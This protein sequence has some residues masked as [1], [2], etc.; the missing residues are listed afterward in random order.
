MKE[1]PLITVIIPVYNAE[2][3]LEQCLDSVRNQTLT[4]LEIICVDDCSQDGSPAILERYQACDKRIKV[5]AQE[6]NKSVYMARKKG[7]CAASGEYIMFLDSDDYL[8]LTACERLYNKIKSEN[9]DILHFSTRIVNIG[10]GNEAQKK[11]LEKLLR[12][13]GRKLTGDDVFKTGLVEKKVWGTL[14]NKLFRAELCRKA[15]DDLKEGCYHIGEDVYT[16]CAIAYHAQSYLGWESEPLH[17]YRIGSGVTTTTAM[18]LKKFERLCVLA[19]VAECMVDFCKIHGVYKNAQEFLN[20]VQMMWLNACYEAWYIGLP[21]ELAGMGWE[22]MCGCWGPE[23]VISKVVKHH[24]EQPKEIARKLSSYARIPLKEK[25]IKTVGIYYH[26]LYAGGVERVISVLTPLLFKMGY[27]VVI[28]TDNPP[29]DKDYAVPAETVREVI[30]NNEMTDWDS[31]DQRCASLA[32]AV[33]K[34]DVDVV[35][36]SAWMSNLLLWDMLLLKAFGIPVVVHAHGVFPCTMLENGDLFSSLPSVMHLADGVVT[37]SE[38]DQKY[39]GLF[40]DNVHCIPNPAS[41]SLCDVK[42]GKW[43]NRSLI[44]VGRVSPEK[45]PERIF[46]IMERVVARIPDA[47]LYVLGD[48]YD[49]MWPELVASKGLTQNV[50]LCGMVNDVSA[51]LE[52]AS[53][54]V[55]TSQYEGFPMSLVEAQA[56]HLP[57]VMFR[58]PHLT[59]AAAD[60][61]VT[62]V[63]MD[64]E[65]SASNEI[66]KLLLDRE[67]WQNNSM[68]AYRSFCWLRDYDLEGAWQALLTGEMTE[69]LRDPLVENMIHTL[70][71]HYELRYRSSES[72]S[73]VIW[74]LRKAVGG[75]ECC[76]ENGLK[77][78]IHLGIRKLQNRFG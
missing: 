55:C 78:T 38:V 1:R 45:Q 19:E 33:R 4:N 53:V 62:S 47:K 77:H 64:D 8:E 54:F 69:D 18:D 71:D 59:M 39:W 58:L 75:I 35:I 29:T 41:E 30:F 57:T 10:K 43:E 16:F 63:D 28:I 70:I 14:W 65:Q 22:R 72:K 23:R 24:Y 73:A 21:R 5:Y 26:K 34:H 31:I 40:C 50:V 60:R 48:F 27:R 7:V 36:Y 13:Y 2:S 42:P 68:M 12:P 67:L 6:S 66:V 61:G 20:G 15:F 25:K 32:D 46:N 74:F 9:V 49:K 11:D 44:W 52:K 3:Y 56:H 76:M 51:Y 37:L 17:N